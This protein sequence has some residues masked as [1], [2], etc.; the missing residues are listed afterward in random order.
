MDKYYVRSAGKIYGPTTEEKIK[1]YIET[2]F[3][4]QASQVSSDQRTWKPYQ[5]FFTVAPQLKISSTEDYPDSDDFSAEIP[6]AEQ[7]FRLSAAN[8]SRTPQRKSW[9]G[10]IVASVCSVLILGGAGGGYFYFT[11][12]QSKSKKFESK[13]V[14]LTGNKSDKKLPEPQ[15]FEEVCDKYNRAV[16]VVVVTLENTK[17]E[18]LTDLWG[19]QTNSTIP[20]GTAFAI[21]PNEFVT[22]SHVAYGL[23]SGKEGVVQNVL[24]QIIERNALKGKKITTADEANSHINSYIAKNQKWLEDVEKYIQQ[25]I[26]VRSVEIRL[27]HSNGKTLNVSGLQVHPR[28]KANPFAGAKSKEEAIRKEYLNAEYDVAIFTTRSDTDCYFKIADKETLYS[29][30]AGSEIAYMGFPMEGLSEQ[31]SLNIDNPEATFKAGSINKI[32][33][34]NHAH[35]SPELNRAI[36]HDLPT[37]GGASG[38][39]IFNKKGEVVAAL[40]GGDDT[41]RRQDGTRISSAAQHNFAVRI[42]SLDAVKDARRYSWKEWVNEK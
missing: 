24:K 1:E 42:D 3:F 40:W 17:G 8:I 20:L 16:G 6:E 25:N 23:R 33:D 2:G 34:F 31:G 30:K 35:S 14:S 19:W 41:G 28:Y 18:L 32:T 29:L 12:T 10:I 13:R 22:N 26:R 27:S 38:S 36:V 4:S 5:Q 39:P 21:A 9:T 11:K 15:S 37:V 7:V